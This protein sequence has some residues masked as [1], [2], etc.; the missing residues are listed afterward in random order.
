MTQQQT[1]PTPSGTHKYDNPLGFKPIRMMEVEISEPLHDI[2]TKHT[3]TDSLY[4]EAYIL[5]RLFTQPIGLIHVD[6][7]AGYLS[8]QALTDLIWQTL[9]SEINACLKYNGLLAITSLDTNGV[10]RTGIPSYLKEQD[11]FLHHA[12]FISII[13]PTRERPE[14]LIITLKDLMDLNYPHYEVIVVDNAPTSEA[15]AEVVRQFIHSGRVRYVREECPGIEWARN[16]G[17][18]EAKSDIVAFTDDDVRVDRHWLIAIAQ[19]FECDHN[20]ACVTG[21]TLPAELE[22]P[23]QLWFEQFGGFNKGFS[24]RIY[25]LEQHKPDDRLFPYTAGKF[26]SGVNMAIRT[27]VLRKLSGF[28]PS[29]GAGSSARAGGDIDL[30]FRIVTRGYQLVYE[31]NAIIHHFHR[32]D[33][34]KLH[35]QIYNYGVGLTAF[36]TKSVLEQPHR[37]IDIAKKLPIGLLYAL[38]PRSAKNAKKQGSYPQELT[39]LELQGMLY[40]PLAYLRSRQNVRKQMQQRD[41]Q[42]PYTITS[43]TEK[44]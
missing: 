41:N 10:P 11:A 5:V 30:Y 6:L 15:T 14:S 3:D 35:R 33:Y 21:L 7:E 43:A 8:A 39:K 12:P 2:S 17:V 22:A 24:R 27:S 29:L 26:G 38:N 1:I 9:H 25:D 44:T 18:A 34:A 37:F 42:Q 23:S 13:I 31:P 4:I 40:G 19:A 16:R 28:D 32:R 36:L 20:V